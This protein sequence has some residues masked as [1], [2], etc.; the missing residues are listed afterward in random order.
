MSVQVEP[1]VLFAA[2]GEPLE[3][4]LRVALERH[5]LFVEEAIGE[6]RS[7][8]RLTAPDFVI[9]GGE[10]TKDGGRA[11]LEELAADPMT[12]PVPVIVIGAAEGLDGRVQAFRHGAVA[13]VPRVP[14][15]D[16]LGQRI[17]EIA[18]EL[19]EHG[20]RKQE[21]G[22]ATLEDLVT[23]VGRELRAGLL[24]VE[25]AQRQN[26]EGPPLRIVLGAGR[27]V[28]E[29]VEEFVRKLSPLVSRAEPLIYELHQG[30]GGTIALL[31]GDSDEAPVDEKILEGLRFLLL[32]SDA[33][34]ADALATELRARKAIVVV[35]DGSLQGLER[36]RVLDPDVVL[37]DS[38]GME[39]ARFDLARQLRTDVR[40][41]W[42]SLV[43]VPWEEL[44]TR[45]GAPDIR[46]LTERVAPLV[47]P[48]R[49]LRERAMTERSFETRLEATGP[50]RLIRA[51]ATLPGPFHVSVRSPKAVIEVDVAEGLIVGA[52]G[53]TA[54]GERLE[55]MRALSALVALGSG[56]ARIEMR[57]HAA[58]AN[59]M[60]P[61]QQA[62]AMAD[63]ENAPIPLSVPPPPSR[64][65]PAPAPDA[66]GSGRFAALPV[67]NTRAQAKEGNVRPRDL[68]WGEEMETVSFEDRTSPGVEERTREIDI[69]LV[70][71]GVS[72]TTGFRTTLP[73]GIANAPQDKSVVGPLPTGPAAPG[74]NAAGRSAFSSSQSTP[75]VR[76][77]VAPSRGGAPARMS[78]LLPPKITPGPMKSVSGKSSTLVF[79]SGSS[80]LSAMATPVEGTTRPATPT[81][82]RK[83]TAQGLP[84]PS[85][86]SP[87]FAPEHQIITVPVANVGEARQV[88][89]RVETART[90]RVES[91]DV[92]VP[93]VHTPT[94]HTKTLPLVTTNASTS[95]TTPAPPLTAPVATPPATAP[96]PKPPVKA[97]VDDAQVTTRVPSLEIEE[98]ARVLERSLSGAKVPESD[99]LAIELEAIERG[100]REGKEP[101][102]ESFPPT[103]VGVPLGLPP[104]PISARRSQPGLPPPASETDPLANT[105]PATP[106]LLAPPAAPP[107]AP[108]PPLAA[109]VVASGLAPIGASAEELRGTSPP[110]P[111]KRSSW[112]LPVLLLGTPIVLLA[113]AAPFA[114]P[115]IQAQIATTPTITPTPI[116]PITPVATDPT[117]VVPAVDPSVI[118]AVE[119]AIDPLS[120]S[121]DAGTDAFIPEDAFEPADAFE[122][123]DAF[124]EPD[125]FVEAEEVAVEDPNAP[126]SDAEALVRQANEARDPNVKETLFR[127]ALALDPRNHYAMLGLADIYM[128]RGQPNEAI[129]LIEGAI[130]RRARRSSY[131]VLLGDARRAAGDMAGAR[132]AWQE[133]LEIDPNDRLAHT[134]LG[135]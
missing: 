110:P 67:A 125:A 49:T 19:S 21:L 76:T 15:A 118:V 70:P 87:G 51:L 52:T 57:T 78:G 95:Q 123:P 55:A 28:A 22:E 53:A 102:P 109:P 68:K 89:E 56:R 80:R 66:E 93:V 91:D 128:D 5:G 97:D 64:L 17:A 88:R 120:A 112:W 84:S 108:T 32:D 47:V 62:F 114:W 24:S 30:P 115:W 14:S 100:L 82:R 9:L 4:A 54:K 121:A 90:Q 133:A 27:P 135:D 101:K 44:W 37:V 73:N 34:R 1:T 11:A 63:H 79:G 83:N 126:P 59:L 103:P 86:S 25:P 119:P 42:A 134:R 61:V 81:T 6:L 107:T 43:V 99:A 10:L 31:D 92:I 130:R 35:S 7:A 3:A 94:K 124:T 60:S 39:G 74:R 18:R 50:S 131:R 104:A 46:K 45:D 41:R 85:E 16:A 36:A 129:P 77:P 33:T 75:A 127:R 29:V 98:A 23:L 122:A 58:T 71:H 105:V 2:R 48:D 116:P 72:R 117:N 20:S 96:T 132:A 12:A 8:V 65:P 13:V 111:R 26:R 69:P 113:L 38:L 40:L 106:A